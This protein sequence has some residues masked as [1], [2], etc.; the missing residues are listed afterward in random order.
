MPPAKVE[1]A[2]DDVEIIEP[3]MTWPLSVVDASFVD[4]VEVN[5]PKVPL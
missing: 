1:V 4:E 5:V 3:R 2:A